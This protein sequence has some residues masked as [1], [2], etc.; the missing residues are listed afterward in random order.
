VERGYALVHGACIAYGE[1]AFL[2]TAR[3]D[4]GKTTTMLKILD[5]Y[6][7]AFL[8]D[9]LTLVAPDGGVLP[10]AK[11]LTISRHTLHAVRM[12][13]LTRKERLG[14]YVQSRLHSRSGRKFAFLL[15]KTHLPVATVNTVVQLLVPPPKYA[16]QR[17]VPGVEIR[18]AAKLSGMFVIER[19]GTG[20][21]ELAPAE[22]LET[23][24]ENCEDAYGFPPYRE[25]EAFLHSGAGADLRAREREI[26][27][28]AFLGAPAMLLRSETMDWAERIP[29]FIRNEEAAE[30]LPG[31]SLADEAVSAA[32]Q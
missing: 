14:L 7:C 8:S 26:I 25:I 22:A 17:L 32:G 9:D 29:A 23:L 24:L 3:T 30:V 13:L 2:V 6:D 20:E 4:T 28:R 5:R 21:R 31:S 10:Y 18:Q 19:G 11:P 16:V 12:P 15:A 1:R 27:T